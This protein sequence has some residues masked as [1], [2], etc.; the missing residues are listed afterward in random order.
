MFRNMNVIYDCQYLNRLT[1]VSHALYSSLYVL[2]SL[3]KWLVPQD[4]LWTANSLLL[5]EIHFFICK[6][7]ICELLQF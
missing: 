5:A 3:L 7:R 1:Y 4:L 6:S 2:R